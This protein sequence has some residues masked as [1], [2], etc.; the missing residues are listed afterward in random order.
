MIKNRAVLMII[1]TILILILSSCT[2]SPAPENTDEIKKLTEVEIKQ[3]N[4]KNLSSIIDVK[5]VSIKGPQNVDTK[6]YKLSVNGLVDTPIDFTY[7]EVLSSTK[8]S[9]V[10]TLNCVEGWSANILWEGISLK[11]LFDKVK[12][13]NTANTV[14]FYSVDGYTTSLPLKTILDKN[15][16]IAYKLNGV[17]LPASDGYPF[18]LVAEDKLGYKWIKWINH[19]ELSS[20]SDYKGYWE[21]RGYSNEGN[22]KN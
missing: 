14:I 15:L 20:N 6:T 3:Y 1:F 7:D 17:V 8:Y 2:R 18:I 16:L 9:K 11:D 5:D 21:S 12:V 22:V 13:K 4:G 19:I 10:V